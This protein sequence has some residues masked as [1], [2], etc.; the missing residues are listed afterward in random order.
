MF[1]PLH[2]IINE[3]MARFEQLCYQVFII[4]PEGKALW[5]CIKEQHLL[6]NKIDATEPNC[7]Q[8]A[9]FDAGMREAFLGLYRF[10][11]NYQAKQ[12]MRATNE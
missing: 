4:S 6:V 5:E 9:L 8:I 3:E 1:N 7:N 11:E 10:A 12:L 2:N